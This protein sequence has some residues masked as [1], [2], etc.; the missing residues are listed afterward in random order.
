VGQ[1]PPVDLLGKLEET[2]GR[3]LQTWSR[4]WLETAG[5]NTLRAELTVDSEGRFTSFAV[6]QEAPSENP[7]LRPHRLAI[8]CYDRTDDGL[9]RTDRVELDLAGDR[10]EVPKLVGRPRPDLVLLNDDDLTYA[11]IRLDDAS[12]RTVLEGISEFRDSLPRTLC[13][14]AAWDMT[15]DAEMAPRDFVELVLSGIAAESDSSVV[16][17]LLRQ[18]DA[19][20]TLYVA[21]Q[22]RAAAR[23]RFAEGIEALMR[24]APAGSDSQLQFV[25]SFVGTSTSDGQLAAV[26]AL[27]DGSETL[28]GL[29]IDTDL[30]WGLLHHL[31]ASGKAGDAEIDASWPATTP[32]PAGA[33]PRRR[34]PRAPRR[35][36]SVR[37]G[38]RSSSATTCPTPCRARSSAGSPSGPGG[39][40]RR[41]RR[42]VLRLPDRHLGQ[43]DQRDGAVDRRRLLPHAARQRGPAASHRRVARD[44]GGARVAAA[45]VLE[46]RDGVARALRAQAR[47]AA[48]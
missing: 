30:R 3:D 1:H 31:V 10:T 33:T 22:H 9:V 17:V 28:E 40:A 35:R 2:S 25:R 26:R 7:V 37:R 24:T 18:V 48:R 41:V 6:L 23:T 46:S 4:L 8:G 29:L 36:R 32:P 15:R 20:L 19:A 42:A 43:P 21:P 14:T 11:K 27:F 39:A 47:D 16:R 45:A 5:V 38:R 34:G 13:W 12:L 44:D